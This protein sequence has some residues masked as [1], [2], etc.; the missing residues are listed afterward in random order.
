MGEDFKPTLSGEWKCEIRMN[1]QSLIR[2][3]I[4]QSTQWLVDEGHHSQWI[5]SYRGNAPSHIV[6]KHWLSQGHCAHTS[7]CRLFKCTSKFEVIK[8]DW[9]SNRMTRIF[10]GLTGSFVNLQKFMT[11]SWAP[12]PS[13]SV[14]GV[15]CTQIGCL[16]ILML[17]MS[18]FRSPIFLF[19]EPDSSISLHPVHNQWIAHSPA[20]FSMTNS[21][22]S[23]L[24]CT[25]TI[26]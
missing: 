8:P 6:R 5:C 26:R 13:L 16:C 22:H 17:L 1:A 14:W 24:C 15:K 4:K 2:R 10:P 20:R 19:G 9:I 11:E 7:P 18:G 12:L 23:T 25:W 21:I 3:K